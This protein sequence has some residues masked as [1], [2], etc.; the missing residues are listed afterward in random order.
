MSDTPTNDAAE[1][2]ANLQRLRE[3][4]EAADKLAE[5]NRLLKTSMAFQQAGIDTSEGTP[6]ALVFT[7]FKPE[8]GQDITPDAVL[9]YAQR[10]GVAPAAKGDEQQEP[11]S[12]EQDGVQ[13]QQQAEQ[14]FF[15]QTSRMGNATDASTSDPDPNDAAFRAFDGRMKEGSTRQDAA[16]AGMSEIFA[17]AAKGDNRAVYDQAKWREQHR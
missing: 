11:Q 1:E 8:D 6:G 13:P 5:E 12:Q 2:S 16:A 14:E 9:E 15:N 7:T 4:A 3:K 17:A 10:F